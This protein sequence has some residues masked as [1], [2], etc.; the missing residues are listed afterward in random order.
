MISIKRQKT[1]KMPNIIVAAVAR[2]AVESHGS[3]VLKCD[4]KDSGAGCA[5]I[6]P[7]W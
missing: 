1:K 7:G 6:R 2:D 5:V 3:S 4:N